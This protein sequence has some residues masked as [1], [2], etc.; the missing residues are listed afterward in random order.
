MWKRSEKCKEP[1]LLSNNHPQADTLVFHLASQTIWMIRSWASWTPELSSVSSFLTWVPMRNNLRSPTS[2]RDRASWRSVM[3][4]EPGRSWKNRENMKRNLGIDL[5]IIIASFH[6]EDTWL[7]TLLF[8]QCR[9]TTM[10]FII[11]FYL[12]KNQ[13]FY[14]AECNCKCKVSSRRQTKCVIS[15]TLRGLYGFITNYFWTSVTV[16]KIFFRINIYLR[17][18][19]STLINNVAAC[20]RTNWSCIKSF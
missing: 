14:I 18:I 20:L 9:Q 13:Y 12:N 6:S 1:I 10:Q 5:T 4:Q 8:E 7:K 16:L 2:D 11:V 3:L 15:E 17:R 19:I